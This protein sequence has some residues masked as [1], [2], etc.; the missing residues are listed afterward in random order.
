MSDLTFLSDLEAEQVNGGLFNIT[1]I[2][3]ITRA[4]NTGTQTS[5]GGAGGAATGG[6]SLI[7]GNGGS[8]TSGGGAASNTGTQTATATTNQN[9]TFLS[10]L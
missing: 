6:A 7:A 1:P 9:V 10:L 8:A 5:T 3:S 2:F 4:R